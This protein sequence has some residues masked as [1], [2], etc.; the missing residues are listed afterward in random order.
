MAAVLAGVTHPL[1]AWLIHAATSGS[2]TSPVLLDATI[3]GEFIHALQHP[4]FVLSA[5]LF[6]W[7]VMIAR[8]RA[9]DYGA[10]V[11]YVFTTAVHSGLLGA[12]LTFAGGA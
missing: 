4:S 11:P 9:M 7:A 10:A 3:D 6:W 2:G 1:V 5:L 8:F 12:L